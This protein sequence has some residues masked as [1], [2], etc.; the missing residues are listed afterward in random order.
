MKD[1][2]IYADGAALNNPFGRNSAA[3]V[4]VR[5][6]RAVDTQAKLLGT[7]SNNIA[8]YHALLL[9]LY[10]AAKHGLRN[11]VIRMDSALVVNQVVGDWD[12]KKAHLVPLRDR[13][14]KFMKTF[15]SVDLAWIPRERNE[16]ADAASMDVLHGSLAETTEY[17][18]LAPFG[19]PL[20]AVPEPRVT[21]VKPSQSLMP[22][23][24]VM[25]PAEYG[26]SRK[27]IT[28]EHGGER[29]IINDV[30]ERFARRLT[31]RLRHIDGWTTNVTETNR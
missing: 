9:A 3:A 10:V 20:D 19:E 6:G 21:T 12:C 30:S 31:E 7:G 22:L 27:L 28:I 5:E 16:A 26:T 1:Y 24:M 8:E 15:E 4:L 29:A 18:H 13:A 17:D 11:P 14:R 2:V 25:I 23:P